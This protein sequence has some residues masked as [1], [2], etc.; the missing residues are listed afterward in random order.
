MDKFSEPVRFSAIVVAM[1]AL[2]ATA[3]AAE[4][5][6]VG[7]QADAAQGDDILVLDF[8]EE[9]GH[10]VVYMTGDDATTGDVAGMDLLV[11]SSTLGSGSVRGKF[12][13]AAI[14][15]LQWEEAL[16]RWDHND[17][18]GNFRM[19][20]SSRNGGG[21]ETTIIDI[22]E[23]AVGHPLAAG[24]SAGPQEIFDDFNRTPQAFGELAPD[25]IVIG[26]LDSEFAEEEVS[27]FSGKDDL[28]PELVL[29]AIDKGGELGPPGDGFFAPE[30]RVNFPIE[31]VGFGFLNEVGLQLF[32]ASV[33]W[34]L[35]VGTGEPGDF[36]KDGVLDAG[37]IDDLTKQSADGLNPA[38]YDLNSDTRV[39]SDDVKVWIRDLF[40]SWVGDA[41]LDGEFN[42]GDLVV[43][44][45]SGTYEVDVDSVWSTGDF[46]GNGRT[47]TGDLVAALSD[48]GYEAGARAAVAAVPEPTGC[49]LAM[50]GLVAL[51]SRMRRR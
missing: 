36:N 50:L 18:D 16:I 26:A 37:D 45:A 28:F 22:V 49:A 27:F 5:L 29:T 41:N 39:D 34:L 38:E 46:D 14:P 48:G 30:K 40:N 35:G 9:Q 51:V 19:S 4:I 20:E 31:D 11:I 15:I 13:D 12:Q 42:S 17:P 2:V 21:R 7:G 33:N 24:L 23:S 1:F 8:L 44:L 25:L 3:P 32:D 47:N 6:F 10:E 43:V